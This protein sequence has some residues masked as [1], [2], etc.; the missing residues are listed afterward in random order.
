MTHLRQG[1]QFLLKHH[2][3]CSNCFYS[4]PFHLFHL[5]MLVTIHYTYFI[6]HQWVVTHSL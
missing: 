3:M 2:V 1:T 6:T 5:K 4:I